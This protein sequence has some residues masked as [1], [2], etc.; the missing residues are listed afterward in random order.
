MVKLFWGGKAMLACWRVHGGSNAAYLRVGYGSVY[1]GHDGCDGQDEYDG[2]RASK[3]RRGSRRCAVSCTER[4]AA[5]RKT[6]KVMYE[7]IL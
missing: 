5:T 3:G 1:V 4:G 7:G 6:M 2:A